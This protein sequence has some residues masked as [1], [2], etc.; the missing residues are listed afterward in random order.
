MINEVDA[1]ST[2]LLSE[3]HGEN[4]ELKLDDLSKNERKKEKLDA[5]LAS[6]EDNLSKLS[7]KEREKAG[8]I[9]DAINM[10]KAKK[11]AI[12]DYLQYLD[13]IE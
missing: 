11:I 2:A 8:E 6:G 5:L 1:I 3:R 9:K 7:E 10:L 12:D 13:I 4:S